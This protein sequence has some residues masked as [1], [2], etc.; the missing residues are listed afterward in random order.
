MSPEKGRAST[1]LVFI[2]L[3]VLVTPESVKGQKKTDS[4]SLRNAISAS[5]VNDNFLPPLQD[6][7][8]TNGFQISYSRLLDQ[9]FVGKKLIPDTERKQL[10]HFKFGQEIYTPRYIL[11]TNTALMDRPYA[12]Y[13]FL[14]SVL[15]T[16][17]KRKN[18][19]RLG[20][21]LGVIGPSSGAEWLQTRWH[22]WFNFPQPRG[23]EY[24]IS[25]IPVVNM[26][27][28]YTHSWVISSGMDFISN[29]KVQAGTAFNTLSSGVSFRAGNINT[30]D[31]SALNRSQLRG[32]GNPRH[33]KDKSENEWY[34]LLGIN[35]SLVMH[36]ALI[37][38]S[39]LNPSKNIH[40][41]DAEPLLYTTKGGFAYSIPDVTWKL[42]MHQLSKEVKGGRS[43]NYVQVSMTVRF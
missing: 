21:D 16:F 11:A 5:T 13:L 26:D 12:G 25:N 3:F 9:P 37:E 43:H 18:S 22:E 14:R 42:M 33:Q 29:S 2:L 27:L 7:Y 19:L 35:S 24:Q 34:F 30:I 10:L 8:F 1:L 36:N 39:V 23:W 41:E 38:G 31:H 32:D 6:H 40:T 17:W 15:D 4:R 20:L 28:E